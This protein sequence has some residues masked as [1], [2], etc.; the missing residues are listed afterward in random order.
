MRTHDIREHPTR[1]P[2]TRVPNDKKIVVV[3]DDFDYL[4]G[5]INTHGMLFTSYLDWFDP[6]SEW[7]KKQRRNLLF[8]NDNIYWRGRCLGGGLLERPLPP[9]PPGVR[10]HLKRNRMVL[11]D[12]SPLAVK[13]MKKEDRYRHIPHGGWYWHQVLTACITGSLH[14]VAN[15]L[16]MPFTPQDEIA[17]DIGVVVP[18][19]GP[20][21]KFYDK[22]KLVPDYVLGLDRY[23]A[24]EAD[25]GTETGNAGETNPDQ[26]YQ[27]KSYDRMVRQYLEFIARKQ[28]DAGTKLYHTAYRIPRHKPL[29]VLF[30]ST[31][32]RKLKLLESIIMERTEGR[33]CNF[34]LMQHVPPEM[35]DPENSPEPLTHLWTMPWKRA[36]KP[37]FY[38]SN[39]GR[40]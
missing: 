20:D 4:F 21:G 37:D 14:L 30:V 34:I 17:E 13:L 32:E 15:E 3:Q 12:L 10:I 28:D 6:R 23:Y 26:F 40:Q 24:I 2:Y 35:I 18:Y 33:G 39:P 1:F 36:G 22:H 16:K 8:N 7:V 25:L 29:M 31:S 5:P 19:V 27:K 11:H 38:I 9:Q